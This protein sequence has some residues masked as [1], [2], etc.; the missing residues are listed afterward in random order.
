MLNSIFVLFV[1]FLLVL[2][3]RIIMLL[4]G[5]F[6]IFDIIHVVQRP[7]GRDDLSVTFTHK[8]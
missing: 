1:C 6:L 5:A 8:M 2:F 3:I 7:V 4:V